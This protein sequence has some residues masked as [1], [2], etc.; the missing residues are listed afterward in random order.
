MIYWLLQSGIILTSLEDKALID[1]A[2][3]RDRDGN[4]ANHI[5]CRQYR[6]HGAVAWRRLGEQW[7]QIPKEKQL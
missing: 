5:V 6:P 1:L 3:A 2:Q 7:K 4:K